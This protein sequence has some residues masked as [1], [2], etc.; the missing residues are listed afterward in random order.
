MGFPSAEYSELQGVTVR[1]GPVPSGGR[2]RAHAGRWGASPADRG[3]HFT[4]R[5][6]A[7]VAAAH[8]RAKPGACLLHTQRGATQC[9]K[10]LA[11]FDTPTSWPDNQLMG[12]QLYVDGRMVDASGSTAGE[13]SEQNGQCEG[14][15]WRYVEYWLNLT[16]TPVPEAG[17][18]LLL[19]SGISTLAGWI[20]WQRRRRN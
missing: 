5:V 9:P 13:P 8:R 7:D 2:P 20:A 11:D 12:R 16:P 15:Q 4:A 18:L 1:V 3:P 10:S 17:T 19:G 14:V 6:T